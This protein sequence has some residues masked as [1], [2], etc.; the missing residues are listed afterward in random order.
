MTDLR[1]W[2][3]SSL[4]ATPIVTAVAILSLAL[5][6]G[7]NTAIFSL[8]DSL[9]L[10]ALP[11][12]EPQRLAVISDTRAITGGFTAGWPYADLGSNPA[13]A[14]EP[15]DGACAWMTD[16]FNLAQGGG[17]TQPVD[18]IYASGDYF[19]TLGVP[20]AARPH[21]HGGRRCA[22]AAAR[23]ARS[24][25]SATPSGSGASAAPA[26]VVGTPLV[27]ERVPF[28]IIGVTPPSFFGTEI[29]R[30]A[31]V[32]LPI[33]HRAADPRQGQPDRTRARFLWLD[34][35]AAAEAGTVDRQPRP[36]S[37]AACSRRFA[38]PRDRPRCRRWRRRKF[39]KDAMT[40][41]RPAPATS[42]LRTRY[43]RPLV[44]VFVVVGA[45]AADR[46]REHRQ[47][48]AGANDGAPA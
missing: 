2:P 18:G 47:P 42:R 39:L 7:A 9:I 27:V 14:R 13:S 44:A 45:G 29:G 26:R 10:R 3:F 1:S 8:V 15:F 34:G 22:L 21:V 16:R 4:R 38:R 33:E 48:A 11:V 46:V 24:P 19:S 40:C 43:E 12:V 31:D 41:C 28:T 32:V 30:A 35:L 23:T 36:R 37:S 25:S 5:G 20:G 17:E 6:I